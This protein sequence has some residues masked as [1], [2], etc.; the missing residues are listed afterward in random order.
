MLHGPAQDSGPD[1]ASR[2]KSRLGVVMCLIYTVIYAGF[3][4]ANVIAEGQVMQ[5]MVFMGLN[6]AV[7]YGMGLIIFALVLALIYN[8]MCARKEK[9]LKQDVP[10]GEVGR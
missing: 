2:Y 1:P 9:Q 4:L 6:L 7:V 5:V 10:S 3:V 8:A